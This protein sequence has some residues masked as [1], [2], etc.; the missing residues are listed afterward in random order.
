MSIYFKIASIHETCLVYSFA[1]LLV[2]V[3]AGFLQRFIL[4]IMNQPFVTWHFIVEYPLTNVK[5][6]RLMVFKWTFLFTHT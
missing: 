3:L 6:N 4:L 1:A 2:G 5:W